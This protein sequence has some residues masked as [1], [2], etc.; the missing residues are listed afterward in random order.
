MASLAAT[1]TQTQRERDTAVKFS[2]TLWSQQPSERPWSS[3]A[4]WMRPRP[5]WCRGSCPSPESPRCSGTWCCPAS[6][7]SASS[8]C[9]VP[10]S[11]PSRSGRRCERWTWRGRPWGGC[12]S[13][14]CWAPQ[15]G[16]GCFWA[17]CPRSRP[18]SWRWPPTSSCRG[19]LW[20]PAWRPSR[21]RPGT[22]AGRKEPWPRRGTAAADRTRAYI[23]S[24]SGRVSAG[25][26]N[27]GPTSS[28]KRSAE[29]AGLWEPAPPSP[30]SCSPS[31][32]ASLPPTESPRWGWCSREGWPP[33]RWRS[34][35]CA[36][37]YTCSASGWSAAGTQGRTRQHTPSPARRCY[38][39]SGSTH[40]AEVE[41]TQRQTLR[42][43]L[44]YTPA[45]THFSAQR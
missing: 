16:R 25:L 8:L 42:A 17:P 9:S 6:R 3:S 24:P 29:L 11:A 27:A 43:A 37:T 26:R 41:N 45:L 38:S 22:P 19:C 2:W 15:P 44:H 10:P 31:L 35:A 18:W 30:G 12:R 13:G 20:T 39:T 21:S 7:A 40:P 32:Q 33:R 36:G 28:R 1:W 14:C 23:S 34:E 5:L 4:A